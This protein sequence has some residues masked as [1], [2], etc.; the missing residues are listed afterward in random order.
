[1]NPRDIVV[2]NNIIGRVVETYGKKCEYRLLPCNY[3][4]YYSEDLE[5]ITDET[6]REATFDEKILFIEEE[7]HWGSVIKTYCIGEYQIIEDDKGS[8]HLY[9]DFIDIGRSYNSL[10]SALIGAVCYKHDGC[11]ERASEYIFKMLGI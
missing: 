2:H 4:R 8:F 11:N 7:Y 9:I 10:D 5:V 6:I 3:G 1:M